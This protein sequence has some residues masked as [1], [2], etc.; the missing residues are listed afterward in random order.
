MKE[1]A[2]ENII[3]GSEL[4]KLLGEAL[5]EI[6][7]MIDTNEYQVKNGEGLEKLCK[8]DYEIHFKNAS[9]KTIKK[10]N[11]QIR[12]W[13]WR[14]NRHSANR[15]IHFLRTRI[16][17]VLKP[18]WGTSRYESSIPSIKIEPSLKE[19]LIQKKREVWKKLRDETEKARM[20]YVKEKGDFYKARLYEKSVQKPSILKKVFSNKELELV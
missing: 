4:E 9:W 10:L 14:P 15:L 12:W 13:S 7:A 3:K 6:R 5:G 16:L 17:G 1:I 8:T 20:D 18:K 19:Q 11:K 2:K